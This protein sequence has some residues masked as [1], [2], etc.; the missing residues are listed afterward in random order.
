MTPGKFTGYNPCMSRGI[1]SRIT[2]FVLA[3][4]S[5]ISVDV[6][7]GQY[8]GNGVEI[9]QIYFT[10]LGTPPPSR[11]VQSEAI[12]SARS[13]DND[14][15]NYVHFDGPFI[16]ITPHSTIVVPLAL[17]PILPVAYVIPTVGQAIRDSGIRGPPWALVSTSP[18]CLRGP[19]SA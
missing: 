8:D 7:G 16:V 1:L 14:C 2:A 17:L 5:L 3:L 4:T 11:G 6:D 13:S 9:T 18:L 15:M 12:C 10:R 19:P